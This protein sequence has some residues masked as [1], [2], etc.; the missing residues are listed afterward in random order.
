MNNTTTAENGSGF[1]SP[2]VRTFSTLEKADGAT[3][4]IRIEGTLPIGSLFPTMWGKLKVVGNYVEYY[5]TAQTEPYG[6]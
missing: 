6:V 5:E 1:I 2:S 4:N 3:A